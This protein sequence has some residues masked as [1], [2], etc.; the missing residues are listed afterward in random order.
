MK[1]GTN[2]KMRLSLKTIL[3]Y[4]DNL[5]DTEFR[6]SVEKRIGDEGMAG[7]LVD[8]VRSVVRNPN[9]PVPGRLGEKE[10]L[11][12]NLVAAYLD[13]LLSETE[14]SQFE[15]ICLRSDIYLSEVACTHQI[16]T[17]ILGQPAK[18]N[19]D[20]RLRIY[21]IPR[22]RL[23]EERLQED[24]LQASGFRFQYDVTK[25][26]PE[27]GSPKPEA[28]SQN[29]ETPAEMESE[30]MPRK[31]RR[32]TVTAENA[33]SQEEKGM[34][35]QK[36]PDTPEKASHTTL[37]LTSYFLPL[38]S[39]VEKISRL[40][41]AF[42]HQKRH[43]LILMASSLVL[44]FLCVSIYLIAY[45][46]PLRPEQEVVHNRPHAT[47]TGILKLDDAQDN[48]RHFDDHQVLW[49][50][51]DTPLHSAG[52]A[53]GVPSGS[54]L[55]AQANPV[56]SLQEPP[57]TVMQYL[58]GERL[59]TSDF[60]L[61][62]SVPEF[63]P[64]NPAIPGWQSEVLPVESLL[65]VNH[66]M[67]LQPETQQPLE[68]LNPVQ[69]P[70]SQATGNMPNTRAAM[71]MTGNPNAYRLPG[72]QNQSNAQFAVRDRI[73]P[74]QPT[75]RQP[76][77]T[78]Q[79]IDR[80]NVPTVDRYINS[81]LPAVQ[82]PT[83]GSDRE[84]IRSNEPRTF[85]NGNESVSGS[86]TSYLL[87][88]SSRI[89][90]ASFMTNPRQSEIPPHLIEP[91][92]VE[93]YWNEHRNDSFEQVNDATPPLRLPENLDRLQSSD[94]LQASDFRLQER[95]AI[96]DTDAHST[97]P[98]TC[99]LVLDSEDIVLIRDTPTAEWSWLPISK[100]LMHD[101]VLIPAPFR[102][103]FRFP[104]GIV[105]ATE[106]DTR[107]QILPHDETGRPTLGFDCGHLTVYATAN[108]LSTSG[109]SQSLRIVTPVGGG[110][111]RF[112]DANSFVTI[113]SENKTTVKL[114][115]VTRP[116]ESVTANPVFY[117]SQIET[118]VV[119]CPNLMAF[120]AHGKTVYWQ[121][122]GHSVEW[123][124]ASASI[125][126]IDI[127]KSTGPVLLYNTSNVIVTST[128]VWPSLVSQDGR[129]PISK[130]DLKNQFV[131]MPQTFYPTPSKTWLLK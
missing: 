65:G 88:Q 80:G 4:S 53:P 63:L 95:T 66:S 25:T 39:H 114:L 103:T 124:L 93:P 122:D 28:R 120:P 69:Q 106:G 44:L 12:A 89:E 45:P 15:T 20:C 38:T 126:P 64:A 110:V 112:T 71:S 74:Y 48:D 16:L 37:P 11:S 82:P 23:Q 7:Y 30:P 121:K 61:Q 24:R 62:T 87:P 84:Q 5:F 79:V 59:Q 91:V 32:I 35:E 51:L 127:E 118:N 131:T 58:P 49:G 13:G 8:R 111:L 46:K 119:Y 86:L 105:V 27:A 102:A 29:V 41:Q 42:A 85:E 1:F 55:L 54:E 123:E 125:F 97:N 104:N 52:T 57:K 116:Y 98:E 10:E 26:N 81:T 101:I 96:A 113:D 56:Y 47:A 17:T 18:L 68:S 75:Q 108:R 31:K 2:A 107:V 67:P 90:Q 78:I 9:M 130:L 77:S 40:G 109:I 83:W 73:P 70:Y 129:I 94:L 100:Q 3:A 21:A 50:Q 72:G 33:E 92:T 19:R 117:R 115:K 6:F 128:V 14:Q 99:M 60:R 36:N 34:M 76:E 43:R 22:H